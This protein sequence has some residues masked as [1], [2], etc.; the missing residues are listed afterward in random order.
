[1]WLLGPPRVEVDGEPIDVD[2]R[3]AIAVLAYLSVE[4]GRHPRDRLVDLL[5]P[6]TE[7]GRAR[8]S[9][10]RTLSTIRT[11][12]AGQW[13]VADRHVV[14]LDVDGVEVDVCEALRRL[15]DHAHHGG[16]P[17]ADCAPALAPV[18]DALG[19]VFL[20]GFA[21]RG[22]A[23]FERWMLDAADR[24]QSRLDRGAELAER[25]HF[26]AGD[27][28]AALTIAR[29]RTAVDPLA[30]A[31][32]RARMRYESLTGDRTAA[33]ATYRQLV[34]RLDEQLGVPPLDE[35]TSLYHQILADGLDPAPP[36]PDTQTT[37]PRVQRAKALP[38]VG[39]ERALADVHDAMTRT[40]FVVLEGA[41]GLGKTRL[42]EEV[43]SELRGGGRRVVA[44][45]ASPGG[46]QIPFGLLHRAL[47][48]LVDG[49]DVRRLPGRVVAELAQ[50]FPTMPPNGESPA[51]TTAALYDAI[52][53]LLAELGSVVLVIDDL[54][55]A[56][57]ATIEALTFLA[58]HHAEPG[59]VVASVAV[60]VPASTPLVE[61]LR[62]RAATVS[63][64][65]L[66][67]DAVD[68]LVRQSGG[69]ADAAELFART[70]GHP[71]LV[72]ETIRSGDSAIAASV[73]RLFE[74]RIE[75]LSGPA[76]QILEVLVVVGT[77]ASLS[78]LR[79]ASGRS[80]G[81]ADDALHELLAAG[82]VIETAEIIDLAYA[83][84]GAVVQDRVTP[85]RVRSIHRRCA[86]ALTD[87]GAEPIRVARH[88]LA[89]GDVLEAAT[90]FERA[91]DAA[92]DV[93]AHDA[94]LAAFES[95]LAAGH[96]HRRRIHAK[97]AR[98][99]MHA[100]DYGRALEHYETALGDDAPP[101][102][103]LELG[104]LYRRLRRWEL[105]A[106]HLRSLD[107]AD[108][109]PALAA[110]IC[111]ELAVIEHR[112]RSER[113]AQDAAERALAC[114]RICEH[115]DVMAV[116]EN[117][118]AMIDL[119]PGRAF[120]LRSAATRAMHPHVRT[121][122]LNNLAAVLTDPDAAIAVA[123]EAAE[124][125]DACGDR[126]VAAAVHN[127]LADTLRAAG[128]D[129]EAR[130]EV[131]RS[132]ALFAGVATDAEGLDPDVWMLSEL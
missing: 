57:A 128:R 107:L 119:P 1:M 9:L 53:R 38:L 19:S 24:I 3:K 74:S 111:A 71:L 27:L 99:A 28:Q 112:R 15:G 132:V 77:P 113:A 41:A 70:R 90:C 126:H 80:R 84:I 12:A 102:V 92:R 98:T 37:R 50:L 79:S 5:W 51:R 52:A 96:P 95:A 76:R 87:R 13:L 7:V 29:K 65:P 34:A 21:I 109:E 116:A 44:V 114:A 64:S 4:G 115:P 123:R 49:F 127:T 48:P 59:I 18:V 85:P 11:S 22:A 117:A 40:R 91:G 2:T 100:G 54:Q 88:H 6:D 104:V 20:D 103:A 8:S 33:I 110:H 129:N 118:A 63:L 120:H 94:A 67:L 56:D 35:T 31:A 73:R 75:T 25:A 46:S 23:P 131:T 42:L 61:D 106:A 66:D 89:A 122:I 69:S 124:L 68:A 62:R 43:A 17:C 16:R 32:A 10:R 55:W 78:L 97:I 130:D 30:E 83:R 108:V 60:D 14:G 36:P 26:A 39:R 86:R 82:L 121:V 93:L 58:G 101:A 45:S 47:A 81:E 125:A 72:V 105:A